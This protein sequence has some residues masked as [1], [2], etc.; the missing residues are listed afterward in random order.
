MALPFF[1]SIWCMMQLLKYKQKTAFIILITA[2][3][4]D[5]SCRHFFLSRLKSTFLMINAIGPAYFVKE[6]LYTGKKVVVFSVR[7]T[8]HTYTKFNEIKE[9]NFFLTWHGIFFLYS[10]V[11]FL[12]GRAVLS[13]HALDIALFF[14]METYLLQSF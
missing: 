12:I 4:S 5:R 11:S 13:F 9:L 8:K 3:H 14:F 10:F 7:L 2:V 1:Q 6:S